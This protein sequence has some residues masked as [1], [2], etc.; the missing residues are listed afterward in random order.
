M[1]LTGKRR[2][3]ADARLAGKSNKDAAIAAGYS[4]KT[5]GPAGSRLAK[6]PAIAAFIAK[7][8]KPGE[9]APPPPPAPT[10]PSFDVQAAIMHSDPKNFLLVAMNDP[11]APAKLR[12]EAAKALMPFMHKK[13]GETGKKEQ[14]DVDAKKV[15]GRFASAAPPQL[16]A[17]K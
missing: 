11:A 7:Y 6:D 2:A 17:V 9:K 12:V 4:A 14:R 1:E 5:A 15:A 13:P 8:Q 10:A 16:K 3:F